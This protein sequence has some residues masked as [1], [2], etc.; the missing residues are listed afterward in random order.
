MMA[1]LRMPAT[2][3]GVISGSGLAMAKMIGF[4][5]IDLIISGVNAPLTDSPNATSAPL[6]ASASV[7]ALVSTA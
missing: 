1:S 4:S 2:S 6:K 5:A 7:R 3:S